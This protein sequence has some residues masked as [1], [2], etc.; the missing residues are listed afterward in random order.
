MFQVRVSYDQKPYRRLM[1]ETFGGTVHRSPSELTESGRRFLA[2][3]P[4]HTG[5]L[6]IA[7]MF[8]IAS[9]IGFEATAVFRDEAR[10]P[11]RTIPRA[12]YTALILIGVFYTLSAWA[13]ISAWGDTEA[14]AQAG[15]DPG[16]MIV[17]TI[18][19]TLPVMIPMPSKPEEASWSSSVMMMPAPTIPPHSVPIPPRTVISTTFPEVVQF[20]SWRDT[21]PWLIA[22]SP[23]AMPA[24]PAVTSAPA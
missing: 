13:V 1:I 21:K 14:I 23:P 10:D 12:T 17:T 4:N 7:I 16:N 22:N 19:N 15:A 20:T 9:F 6:G 8:A 24:S 3:N 18:T 11:Q 5:S 2:Q